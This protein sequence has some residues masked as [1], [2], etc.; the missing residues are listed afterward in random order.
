MNVEHWPAHKYISRPKMLE[1]SRFNLDVTANSEFQILRVLPR[2][3]FSRV[4]TG[5]RLCDFGG[6][7]SHSYVL[8]IAVT[9]GSKTSAS[10]IHRNVGV[11][12]MGTFSFIII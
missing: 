2:F 1:V 9:H 12:L 7:P 8:A 3:F 6:R 11:W 5:A 4:V 10:S